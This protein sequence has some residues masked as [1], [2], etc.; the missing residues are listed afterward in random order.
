MPDIQRLMGCLLF[1]DRGKKQRQAADSG[2]ESAELASHP[3]ADL[4]SPSRWDAAAVE[5]AKQACSLMGQVRIMPPQQGQ[6]QFRHV[7][8]PALQ[9]FQKGWTACF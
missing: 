4:V 1:A 3:Y 2:A 7:I 6:Q 8:H 9:D 5:F